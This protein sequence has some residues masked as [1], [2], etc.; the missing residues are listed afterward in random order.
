M[1]NF[2]NEQ[3]EEM[4]EENLFDSHESDDIWGDDN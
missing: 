2:T 4:F 1:N 3:I